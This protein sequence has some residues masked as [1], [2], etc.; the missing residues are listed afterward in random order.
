M[1]RFVA[2]LRGVNVGKGRRVPMAE[3]REVLEGLG[4]RA[5]RTL[6]NS[7]N[8][9]FDADAGT[10]EAH[11]DAIAA[12]LLTRL[13]V[14]VPVVVKSAEA[15]RRVVAEN[16]MA[17]AEEE[18]ARFL[19]A[20][21]RTPADVGSLASLVGRARVPERLA[22]T[23]DA[24]YL[25]CPEGISRSDLAA[26]VLGRAGRRVT[27]RNWATV[28]KIDALVRD[29]RGGGDRTEPPGGTHGRSTMGGSM[30]IEYFASPSDFRAWLEEHH[31]RA[32]ELWVGYHKKATGVPSM[33]WPESVDE[34]LCFG[35]I[36]G[37]RRSVDAER[38]VIRF[39]P[40]RKGSVW[41]RVN[42]G[43]V[44]A[45]TAEG[46]MR[47]A[48]LAAYE[49]RDPEKAGYTY[50]E[51]PRELP[52]PYATAFRERDAAAYDFF[53]AQSPSYRRT[54][55]GWILD[56]KREETRLRRLEQVVEASMAERRWIQ[57][58]PKGMT[59]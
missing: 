16:P 33:T 51:R 31:E 46:R 10:E 20:F 2:L 38:Y 45:L 8:A 56:A 59:R 19:V 26:E 35:W 9:V 28:L 15:W 58:A 11:A 34:A 14:A 30:D 4:C 47:A 3:F 29:E 6:L 13:G 18:H 42:L 21:G 40:R 37:V 54:A 17:P 50:E 25:A 57:G 44:E 39:T 36:D 49:G 22:L 23:D 1:P 53:L 5:V 12:A 55:V 41:S 27:T 43:R 52:E 32:A 48:G 24:A 7:G